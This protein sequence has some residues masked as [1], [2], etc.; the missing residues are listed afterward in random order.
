MRRLDRAR[1]VA[2]SA[3]TRNSQLTFLAIGSKARVSLLATDEA[4]STCGC[5]GSAP[6]A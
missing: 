6:S 4:C 1:R 3:H 5:T 2:G